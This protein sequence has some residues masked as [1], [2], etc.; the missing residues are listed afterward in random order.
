MRW[1]AAALFVVLLAWLAAPGARL[2][3][4]YPLEGMVRLDRLAYWSIL[5][6]KDY[7]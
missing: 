6:F 1:A 2:L 5:V 7:S 4:L 3:D